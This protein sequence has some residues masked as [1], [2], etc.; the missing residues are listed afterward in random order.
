MFRSR[1]L[2]KKPDFFEFRLFFQYEYIQPGLD[3]IQ[4]K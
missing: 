3:G 2:K 1:S 4:I